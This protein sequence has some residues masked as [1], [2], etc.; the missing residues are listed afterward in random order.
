VVSF[1]EVENQ[2]EKLAR[3]LMFRLHLVSSVTEPGPASPCGGCR[4]TRGVEAPC[5]V[6]DAGTD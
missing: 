5:R 2:V 6:D 1:D 3:G 4:L